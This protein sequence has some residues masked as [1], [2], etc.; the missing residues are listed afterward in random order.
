MKF[1]FSLSRIFIGVCFSLIFVFSSEFCL[2]E[3]SALSMAEALNQAKAIAIQKKLGQSRQWLKLLHFEPQMGGWFTYS[4]IDSRNFFLSPEGSTEAA[5]ELQA[6]LEAFWNT[7]D[8]VEEKSA[9]C[10]FPARFR[11]LKKHLASALPYWPEKECPRFEKYLRTLKGDSVSLVFSSFYLNNPSSAFGHTFLRI[12]KSPKED[13]QRHELLDYGINYAAEADSGN[14]LIYAFK[15]L[16]G[17]FPGRFTSVPYYFKVREY[18]NAESRDLWEYEINLNAEK[19]EMLIAHIWEL[20]P[21]Y[22]D[23][24]YLTENCSYHMLTALEAADPEIDVTSKVKKWVIPSDTI[25]DVWNTPGLVK[26]FH[27]RPS[28]RTEFFYRLKAL[29]K[30]DQRLLYKM[31]QLREIPDSLND[32]SLIEQRDWLDTAI[33][34]MDYKY[35]FESQKPGPEMNYK[36]QLLTARSQ[37]PLTTEKL[38]IQPQETEYPHAG[39]TS[40]R[41]SLGFHSSREKDEATLFGLKN[42]L[43]SRT[44]LITGYP[45]YAAISFG[46]FQFSHS[47]ERKRIELEDLTMFEVISYSPYSLFNSKF[48]WRIKLGAEKIKEESELNHHGAVLSGGIG[49]TLALSESP[50]ITLFAGLRGSS[51]YL[52][53]YSHYPSLNGL[54]PSAELRWRFTPQWISTLEYWQKRNLEG[55]TKD[56]KEFNFTTQYSFTKEWAVQMAWIDRSYD[57]QAQLQLLYFR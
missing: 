17:F 52:Q 1:I 29:S 41:W 10:I 21:V 13:G 50:L 28:V 34:Y 15:G 6:T 7:H 40:R 48:S 5:A 38:K 55:W 56:F 2:A 49:Y 24:W 45:E 11:F 54:G 19:V 16:F 57:Q 32:R 4:Q 51:Y 26:T 47:Q 27:Y 31:V 14:A 43:H 23:Y 20:G 44:D 46:D 37:I 42:A 12:N 35:I 3:S 39:H 25:Q 22:I 18:N 36:N 30:E 8:Q 9:A 53:N 33:D